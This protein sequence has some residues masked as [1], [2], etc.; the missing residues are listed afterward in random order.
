MCCI[1]FVSVNENLL[2]E[3]GLNWEA[4]IIGKMTDTDFLEKNTGKGKLFLGEP[5]L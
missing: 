1:I 3:T 5:V 4:K 2:C